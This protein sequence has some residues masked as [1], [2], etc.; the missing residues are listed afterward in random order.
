MVNHNS[1][2][3]EGPRLAMDPHIWVRRNLE[4][5]TELRIDTTMY[6]ALYNTGMCRYGSSHPLSWI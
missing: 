5:C 4:V 2:G 1:T 6:K 3:T